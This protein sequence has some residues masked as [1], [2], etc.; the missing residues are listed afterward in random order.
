M[1]AIRSYYEALAGAKSLGYVEQDESLD[2]DGIDA[3]HKLI[4]LAYLS[5]HQ[6]FSVE[7]IHVEGIRDVSLR[8]IRAAERQGYKIKLIGTLRQLPSTRNVECSVRPCLVPMSNNLST[9]DDAFNGICI[10]G[11]IVGTSFLIGRGAGREPTTSAVLSDIVDWVRIDTER[12]IVETKKPVSLAT[13]DQ[14]RQS[15]YLRIEVDDSYN[16]V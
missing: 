4:I 2:L 5:Y 7:D 12:R 14:I 15:Y 1:Y 9:V 6:W 3:A 10:Q 8:D 16:F 13:D 11:D